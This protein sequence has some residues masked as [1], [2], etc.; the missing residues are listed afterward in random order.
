MNSSLRR[1][2]IALCGDSEL[3]NAKEGQ[4]AYDIGKEIALRGAV[5][6]QGGRGGV[7]EAAARGCHE[8]GGLAVAILPSADFSEANPYSHVVIPTGL[9]WTRNS[10]VP[11]A[12]DGIIAIGGQSGTLSEIAFA[13]MYGKPIVAVNAGIQGWASRLAGKP[14]DSRRNDVIHVANSAKEAVEIIL[15]EVNGKTTNVEVN[16]N[17]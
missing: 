12:A 2:Q 5:L 13:W 1:I 16:T 4:I 7:M 3:Q 15:R 14:V 10:L 8:H 11:L 6:I 17:G 9:G